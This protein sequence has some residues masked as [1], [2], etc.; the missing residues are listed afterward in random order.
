MRIACHECDL[1]QQL[2]PV[3]LGGT[4]KC[5]RCSNVLYRHKHDSLNRT[6]AFSLAGLILLSIANAFPFLAFK[7]QGQ[8]TETRLITGV[9]DLYAQG[10]LV[11]ATLVL[12]TTICIPAVQLMLLLYVLVPLKFGRIPWRFPQTFRLL[13]SLTPWSM[14]EIFLLGVLISIV[15]LV[16]MA[17]IVPGLA[18]WA[19]ALLIVMLAAAASSLDPHDVWS[20]VRYRT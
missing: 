14:M 2:P 20:R 12:L 6:L 8:V 4:A 3:P 7:M 5:L 15:K 1:L 13:Q 18:L 10:M 17:T 9:F 11:L 16:D 19:F